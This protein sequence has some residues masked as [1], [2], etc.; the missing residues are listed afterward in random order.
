[1][2]SNRVRLANRV[3]C[4]GEIG[5]VEE[6]WRNLVRFRGPARRAACFTMRD[7]TACGFAGDRRAKKPTSNVEEIDVGR[8]RISGAAES[9]RISEDI[10]DFERA[11]GRVEKL[12]TTRVLQPAE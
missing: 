2:I 10:A 7:V 9:D 6:G 8:K 12:G 11:G 3:A 1:M 4:N 5:S